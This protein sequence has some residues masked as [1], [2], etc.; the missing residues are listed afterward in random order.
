MII[1]IAYTK[2]QGDTIAEQIAKV[3]DNTD[4]K[5][6]IYCY[7]EEYHKQKKDAYQLKASC[8]ARLLPFCAIYND[9][10]E[11]VKAFYSEV[12]ECT[13]PNIL[14]YIDNEIL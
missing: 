7:D 4:E 12:G 3:L 8:G 1:K 6:T 11:I 5:F 9:D 13:I 14:E 2:G 10:K